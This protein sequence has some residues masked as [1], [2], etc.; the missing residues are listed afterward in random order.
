MCVCDRLSQTNLLRRLIPAARDDHVFDYR[1]GFIQRS[2][3]VV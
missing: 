3:L 2:L 1:N